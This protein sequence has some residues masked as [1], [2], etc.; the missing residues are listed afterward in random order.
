M[1]LLLITP[2]PYAP[3]AT[4][5][6]AVAAH[7][8]LEVMALE[9][10]IGVV[11]FHAE[12]S[13]DSASNYL[14]QRVSYYDEAPLQLGWRKVLWARLTSIFTAM[15]IDALLHRSNDMENRIQTALLEFHPDI[16]IIQFPQMAQYVEAITNA[17][18]IM[19]VQ[20]AFSVSS[21]RTFI[22][23]QGIIKRAE[24]F[25]NWLFWIRYERKFYPRFRMM[26][27]LTEQDLNGLRIFSPNLVGDSVG[28]PISV[29]VPQHSTTR[30]PHQIAFVGSF[31][32]RPNVQAVRYFIESILPLI[33]KQIPDVKFLVAG[34]NPPAEIMQLA[35]EHI[36]FVGFVP[37][38]AGFLAASAVVV[39]PLLSGGGIK[40]KTL[41]ALAAG[42]PIVSTSIG[43]EGIGAIDEQHLLVR[44]S[45]IS[46]ADAV[47][48]IMNNS[49][50]AAELGEA[51]QSLMHQRYAPAAWGKHVNSLLNTVITNY[52]G[53]TTVE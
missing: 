16:V 44:D 2:F 36:E 51:G 14:R 22:T 3:G 50:R 17:P 6:G 10:E 9:H 18:C 4:H 11:C 45:A 13:D 24:R 30:V 47:I 38:L 35:N 27:T 8:Q 23:Q 31:G 41:E 1:K 48:Q 12:G 46:F 21:F 53:V 19:D 32:H 34:K 42:A 25:L 33:H 49:T 39:I 37:S 28:V 43:A 5:G 29:D 52:H 40:I 7:A 20:D 15:P 26:L